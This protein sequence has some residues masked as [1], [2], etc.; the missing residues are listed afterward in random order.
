[1]AMLHEVQTVMPATSIGG[2]GSAHAQCQFRM[3]VVAPAGGDGT[4]GTPS[5]E[6]QFQNQFQMKVCE[7][8]VTSS[9]VIPFELS[10]AVLPVSPGAAGGSG[11][12]ASG[13]GGVAVV[14]GSTE[15]VGVAGGDVVRSGEGAD[16]ASTSPAASGIAGGIVD[17]TDG[18]TGVSGTA[19]GGGS[20]GM[21]TTCGPGAE[22]SEAGAVAMI[23]VGSTGL[24]TPSS[25]RAGL[26]ASAATAPHT[27]RPR[28]SEVL[29]DMIQEDMYPPT[30]RRIRKN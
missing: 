16:G 5:S 24:G 7:V 11:G 14:E 23:V 22:L 2:G 13:G 4:A 19:G 28:A 9:L 27:E 17:G 18:I 26:A 21:S 8:G 20:C 30:W 12:D 10:A 25:A 3:I 15:G 1:M 6:E 29:R